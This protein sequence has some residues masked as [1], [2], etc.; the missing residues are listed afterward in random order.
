MACPL[1]SNKLFLS[2]VAE[3]KQLLSAEKG[4]LMQQPSALFFCKEEDCSLS[5]GEEFC[6]GGHLLRRFNLIA[7]LSNGLVTKSSY[8]I[9]TYL[10]TASKSL[11]TGVLS[12]SIWEETLP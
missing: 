8:K 9:D 1:L 6:D 3:N 4:E 7:N 12:S 10:W 5:K 2:P 11:Q